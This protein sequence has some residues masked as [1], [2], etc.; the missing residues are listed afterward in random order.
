M[1]ILIAVLLFVSALLSLRA[2]RAPALE[3]PSKIVDA[4]GPQSPDIKE[5]QAL[6]RVQ[7]Q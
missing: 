3:T 4:H 5:A 7:D 2:E 6:S 1:S